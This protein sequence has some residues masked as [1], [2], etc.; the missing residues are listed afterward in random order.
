[1][2]DATVDSYVN[3]IGTEINPD[4]EADLE[5]TLLADFV[6]RAAADGGIVVDLG[7]GP[8]RVARFVADRSGADV[9]GFDVS[10]AMVA[11]ART[12]HPDLRFDVG[13]LS[14]IPLHAGVADTVIC[15]YSVIHTPLD[16]LPAA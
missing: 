10:S 7:C 14:D 8:G 5:R 6:D 2:Y 16:E 11:A 12:A 9:R 15:W 13:Q 3:R 1:M 4:V